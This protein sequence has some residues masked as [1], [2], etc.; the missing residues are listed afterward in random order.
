MEMVSIKLEQEQN[1]LKNPS[2]VR[3]SPVETGYQQIYNTPPNLVTNLCS[4]KRSTAKQ[5][6]NEEHEETQN[7]KICWVS[8]LKVQER[9]ENEIE[10]QGIKLP[11]PNDKTCHTGAKPTKRNPMHEISAR[12]R[13][14]QDLRA[15]DSIH[16]LKNGQLK[17]PFEVN[18][19]PDQIKKIIQ[20]TADSSPL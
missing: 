16:K 14:T 3:S 6:S 19:P 12:K 9:T 17:K 2:K 8:M 20:K 1:H 5:D 11:A 13:R 4:P 15:T 18:R 7:K 10:W